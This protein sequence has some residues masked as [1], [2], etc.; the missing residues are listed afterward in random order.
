MS[1][2]LILFGTTGMVLLVLTVLICTGIGSVALPIRDIAGI[3]IHKIPWVGDWIT[4]DWNKAAEQIIWKVRFPRVLLAV[5]VGASLAIAGTGFQGVLRNPLADPF[6]LGVSSG[7][8]VGAAFLIFFGLQYALIGI[9][10]L[11][12]VAFLTGVITLWFVMALAREGRKIPTHSLI[13]AGVVMQSFLGAVVSFLS[14]MSK[15]TINEIIYWTMGSL[16]LRGWSYTAILFPYFLLGLV[17]LWSRARSLNVLALGE[18]QA[19][20]IGIG[21][22][23]LKLSVLA[24]GTLLTAGAV[25]VSGVIGFV[26]LVIPH[27]LR[28]LVGPDYRLLVPLSA[29]GGATFMVWADTI[30]RSLLAPTEIPLG[31][32]TAF[33]GAPF[34]AYLL[35]RNKKLQKGMM[36]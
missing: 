11:P 13:L 4:P 19:A 29:I 24:V 2:K 30:A 28:L 16:A 25:S 9:W 7:A 8:S 5:L 14:T 21:V 1:K 6:T 18:R 22:D 32:V 26:G 31:V 34:F 27:M 36:P 35:N 17:F 15:Q 3:L 10:T 12:L 20:H 33:V 23:R